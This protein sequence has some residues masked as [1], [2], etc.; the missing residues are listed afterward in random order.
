MH[1]TT[2]IK[3]TVQCSD[4]LGHCPVFRYIGALSSV[5]IH[6]VTVVCSYAPGA[7][8]SGQICWN[9]IQCSGP[10]S[11]HVVL[12]YNKA[13]SIVQYSAPPF[14]LSP[15][16]YLSRLGRY[17]DSS[18]FPLT[19]S[20]Q[21]SMIDQQRILMLL[22]VSWVGGTLYQAFISPCYFSTILYS[23]LW[24]HTCIQRRLSSWESN[25]LT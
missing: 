25:D 9:I 11:Y 7:L 3:F 15:F 24:P 14:A 23:V 1:G 22:S 4:N 18:R 17:V 6:Q 8:S 5:Q 20:L 13:V 16:S 2:N 12:W 19:K 21:I 10:L